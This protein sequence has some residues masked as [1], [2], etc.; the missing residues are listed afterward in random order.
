M[1]DPFRRDRQFATVSRIASMPL[2][3]RFIKNLLQLYASAVV[4]GS[5]GSSSRGSRWSADLPCPPAKPSSPE[6]FVQVDDFP[7]R[8]PRP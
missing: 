2:S 5:R 4:R 7:F 3:M 8:V 6:D 1:L